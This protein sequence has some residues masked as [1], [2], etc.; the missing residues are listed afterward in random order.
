[1]KVA[2]IATPSER[3]LMIQRDVHILGATVGETAEALGLSPSRVT[4]I[5]QQVECWRAHMLPDW[6]E[7]RTPQSRLIESC[8][9]AVRAAGCAVH[10]RPAGVGGKRSETG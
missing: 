5:C 7:E 1:M 4:A 6:L 10:P 9:Q 2:K 3:D 8:R